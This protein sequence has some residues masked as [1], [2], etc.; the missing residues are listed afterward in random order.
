M[1]ADVDLR[2]L[3]EMS[4]AE[5]ITLLLASGAQQGQDLGRGQGPGQHQA[6]RQSLA[7]QHQDHS[8]P[9]CSRATVVRPRVNPR[10][11]K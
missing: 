4:A 2:Q 11:R 1:F 7:R 9:R 5:R 3:A 8:A 10:T 6:H